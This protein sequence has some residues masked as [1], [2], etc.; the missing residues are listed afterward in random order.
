MLHALLLSGMGALEPSD[1]H[2][3]ECHGALCTMRASEYE[4]LWLSE[5]GGA[6][7]PGYEEV[8]VDAKPARLMRIR[9][10]RPLPCVT[11]ARGRW[12]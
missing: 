4:K 1:D 3:R 2:A 7:K 10:L 6:P 11:Q 9:N 8:V 12:C 5:G